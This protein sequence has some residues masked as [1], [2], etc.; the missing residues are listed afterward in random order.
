MGRVNWGFGVGEHI[1]DF[2]RD[3][4]YAP[5]TGEVPPFGTYKWLVKSVKYVP[6]TREKSAQVRV[7]LELSPRAGRKEHRYKGFFT[8]AFLNISNNPKARAFWVPFADAI[9]VTGREWETKFYT[10]EEGRVTKIGRWVNKG[11]TAILAE[12]R[13]GTDPKYPVNV[14]WMGPL[15]EDDE[16]EEDDEDIEEYEEEEAEEEFDADEDYDEDDEGF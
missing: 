12:I 16:A 3:S 11:D 10:D 6:A 14:G 13:P 2:D 8:M 1:D 5:Y 15:T 9:G 7:G 4:Q